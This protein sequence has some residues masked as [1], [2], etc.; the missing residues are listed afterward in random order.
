MKFNQ[1]IALVFLVM[2]QP[3]K[4][5]EAVARDQQAVQ[6]TITHLF[7]ALS[8]RDATSL[9]KSCTSDIVFYEY[10]QSWNLDTLIMKAITQNTAADFK[11]VNTLEFLDI[12]IHNDIAWATYNNKA[13][14]SQNGK[15]LTIIWLET[16]I[17][18]KQNNEWKMKLLHSTQVNRK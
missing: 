1:F 12:Q 9:K 13:E 10:G 2:V 8:D 4:A 15:R 3:A 18:V 7:D 14:I 6:Q 5:Q 17:L 11:R 16:V